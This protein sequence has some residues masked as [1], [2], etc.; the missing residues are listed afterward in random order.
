MIRKKK[1]AAPVLGTAFAPVPADRLH[2][3]ATGMYFSASINEEG[4]D[5]SIGRIY[6]VPCDNGDIRLFFLQDDHCGSGPDSYYSLGDP[7]RGAPFVHVYRYA[8]TC[9]LTREAS[10][11]SCLA[12]ENVRGV[13]LFIPVCPHASCVK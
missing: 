13:Q 8:W 6:S 12:E 9:L 5:R 2:C 7:R 3:F 4:E 1:R 11:E 10:I